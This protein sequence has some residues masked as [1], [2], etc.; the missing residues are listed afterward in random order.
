VINM[1][2]F[3][4]EIAGE[5]GG[6]VNLPIAQIK[7]VMSLVLKKLASMTRKDCGDVL[8]RYQD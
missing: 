2:K 5:E 6:K 3:A 1:N 8:D 7:E 4:K